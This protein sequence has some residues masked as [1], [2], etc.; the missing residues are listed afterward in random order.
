M[1]NE[2]E[3]IKNI[4]ESTFEVD[5]SSKSRTRFLADK[6]KIYSRLAREKTFYSFQQIGDKIEKNHATIISH[7]TTSEMLLNYDKD[8]KRDYELCESKV[9][10]F[11]AMKPASKS[12]LLIK[13]AY[14]KNMI[15]K[16]KNELKKREL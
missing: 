1:T 15:S 13:L 8:F 7:L 14:H 3:I 16:I 9:P 2:L 5:L 10:E 11:E 12:A 6:K 4:V